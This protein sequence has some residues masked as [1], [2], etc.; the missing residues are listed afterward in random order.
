MLPIWK[1]GT[2][3]TLVCVVAFDLIQFLT[4]F[5][6]PL[7][8]APMTASVAILPPTHPNF[9]FN[10]LG[11]RPKPPSSFKLCW[12]A[13]SEAALGTVYMILVGPF[14]AVICILDCLGSGCY[15]C[16]VDDRSC[17][18]TCSS[19]YNPGLGCNKGC[20][21]NCCL[22]F[23]P[24]CTSKECL[25]R[26]RCNYTSLRLLIINSEFPCR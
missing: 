23:F 24:V 21:T 8:L 20:C 11:A 19:C 5:E 25:D 17:C 10:A 12:D 14:H 15:C 18:S 3:F 7:P 22:H 26:S 13:W 9:Q 6:E 16:C 2:I 1:R 4:G